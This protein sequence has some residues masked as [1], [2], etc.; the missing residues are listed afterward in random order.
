MLVDF[1]TLSAA[2]GESKVVSDGVVWGWSGSG[3]CVCIARR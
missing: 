1:K 2:Q 3:A